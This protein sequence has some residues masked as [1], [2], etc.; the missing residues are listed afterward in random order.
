MRDD[1]RPAMV[2]PKLAHDGLMRAAEYLDDF[3]VGLA[4]TIDARDV[5]DH[6]IA[7]HCRLR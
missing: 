3:S 1:V 4:V 7:V 5:H 6:A 2:K